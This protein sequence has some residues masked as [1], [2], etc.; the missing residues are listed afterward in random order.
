MPRKFLLILRRAKGPSRRTG[1][2]FGRWGLRDSTHALPRDVDFHSFWRHPGQAQRA[3]G[4]GRHWCIGSCGGL[5]ACAVPDLIRDLNT[6]LQKAPAQGRG[7]AHVRLVLLQQRGIAS[8]MSPTANPVISPGGR[9]RPERPG[10]RSAPSAPFRRLPPH[11]S[12]LP[13]GDGKRRS[14][15][16]SALAVAVSLDR[17]APAPGLTSFA[18]GDDG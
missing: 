14:N 4:S 6:T 7:G 18:R 1:G 3:P 11:P 12:P 2:K 17:G 10:E 15:G 16:V 5:A 13:V 8:C 9:G